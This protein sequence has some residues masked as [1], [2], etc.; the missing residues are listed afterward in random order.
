ME[1][2]TVLHGQADCFLACDDI[3]AAAALV[4]QL[5]QIHSVGRIFL[6]VTDAFAA[7]NEA[8]SDST[9]LTADGL[10][11]SATMELVARTVQTDVAL[12]CLTAAPI[13]LGHLAIERMMR[14]AA[15]T[16]AAMLYSDRYSEERPSAPVGFAPQ[17]R[18]GSAAAI[19]RVV[20]PATLP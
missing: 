14:V 18:Q 17:P 19:C 2:D 11:G 20:Q 8:P 16:G 13:T 10:H 7:A 15:D 1:K 9:F 12:L 4:G 6:L 3:R 5:R